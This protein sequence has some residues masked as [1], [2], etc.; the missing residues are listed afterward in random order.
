M[1]RA[2]DIIAS[3]VGLILL[4]PLFLVVAAA[5]RSTSGSPVLFCQLRMGRGLHLFT[6]YKFR[7][8]IVDAANKGG[9]ITSGADPRITRLGAVLR[10]FKIDELPQLINVLKGDMSLVGPRPEMPK[11]VAMFEHDY[12]EILQVRPGITDLA[13]LK[14]QHEAEI[15]EQYENPEDAYVRCILPDKIRLAKEY[16]RQSSLLLDLALILKTVFRVANA[17]ASK[18]PANEVADW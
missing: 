13:S 3:S 6:I 4:A 10:R 11:F 17:D 15:L 9:P 12:R 7:T 8:M 5:V 16:V 2:F 14:Y 1:K 18:V